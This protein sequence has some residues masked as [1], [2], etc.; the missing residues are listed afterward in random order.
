MRVI[1][2]TDLL[3][4]LQLYIMGWCI[5]RIVSRRTMAPPFEDRMADDVPRRW[6]IADG[7]SAPPPYVPV[8]AEEDGTNIRNT[9]L[10][11]SSH[12][13]EFW[14]W[15]RSAAVAASSARRGSGGPCPAD[16]GRTDGET[17]RNED[18]T[19]QLRDGTM[20]L[21]PCRDRP[22]IHRRRRRW[23]RWQ[24]QRGKRLRE[25]RIGGEWDESA[26]M[27]TSEKPR[28]KILLT[29]FGWNH[30]NRTVGMRFG[31]SVRQRELLQAI[32]DHPLFDPSGWDE[33]LANPASI[34]PS[35]RYYVF[36]D[37][38][39]CYE[40]NYPGYLKGIGR[41]SDRAGGRDPNQVLPGGTSDPSERDPNACVWLPLCSAVEDVL[42]AP[43]FQPR[44]TT[45]AT[46]ETPC[47]AHFSSTLVYFD[48]RGDGQP[49][50]HMKPRKF[51]ASTGGS[52]GCSAPAQ[53]PQLA[54]VSLSSTWEQLHPG[55]DQGLPPP[56][57]ARIQL[58]P[59]QI[60]RVRR[61]DE[62]ERPYLLVFVGQI[63]PPE[64]PRPGLERLHDPESGVF[65]MDS[66]E[67]K[68]RVERKK[69]WTID[70]TYGSDSDAVLELEDDA[71]EMM[72]QAAFVATPKGHNRFSYRF[73]EA[74]AAGA[75]PV[76][77][78]DGWVLP[79][80]AEL[81]DW[82][83][84]AVIIPESRVSDTVEILR[85]ISEPER[86]RRRKRCYEIYQQYMSTPEGTIDGILQGLELLTMKNNR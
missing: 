2:P 63:R 33:L 53:K 3:V 31:R 11:T 65:C 4:G 61:C 26:S 14:I 7:P 28:V 69:N 49:L 12:P 79:F 19:A 51:P 9:Q 25:G 67:Y 42:G 8:G 68:E 29:S 47:P 5:I 55:I 39:T 86:C 77:H 32:V 48:C 76:V 54:V 16:K 20:E 64:S 38:E 13:Y 22:W 50:W 75:I 66:R 18:P 36:L 10:V 56:A 41:N 78:S 74:L 40:S 57:V 35:I 82:E 34:D 70:D 80:R 59:D 52:S 44:R 43:L 24:G 37:V 46:A 23:R 71:N 21:A 30:P 45:A 83:E 6:P 73:T 60:R 27:Q 58:S 72:K 62:S 1:R 15:N 17:Q 81:V 85:Q 84:C